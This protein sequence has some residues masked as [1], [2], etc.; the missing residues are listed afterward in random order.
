MD[1]VKRLECAKVLKLST[2]ECTELL[3]KLLFTDPGNIRK[4]AMAALCGNPHIGVTHADNSKLHLVR[5][6]DEFLLFKPTLTVLSI[7]YT[8]F[9]NPVSYFQNH[10]QAKE[11]R[12]LK[13]VNYVDNIPEYRSF[14]KLYEN[15]Y[16]LLDFTKMTHIEQQCIQNLVLDSFQIVDNAINSSTI[17]FTSFDHND[18]L[19]KYY[20]PKAIVKEILSV[21]YMHTGDDITISGI[22][23][24]YNQKCI[25]KEAWTEVRNLLR[26]QVTAIQKGGVVVKT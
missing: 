5:I 7:R 24:Y 10:P 19:L 1:P 9:R 18:L 14:I 25:I 3:S 23:A 13:G 2:E 17:I 22:I 11:Q 16:I 6:L 4:I 26:D 21:V 15:E 20:D 12:K 8:D